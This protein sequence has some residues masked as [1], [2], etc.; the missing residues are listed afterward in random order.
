MENPEHLQKVLCQGI[1]V[2]FVG[3][4]VKVV[5]MPDGNG[6]VVHNF[7]EEVVYFVQVRLG[8]GVIF[9]SLFEG[10]PDDLGEVF[11]AQLVVWNEVT[12]YVSL[13]STVI[14]PHW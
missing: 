4:E 2:V 5:A 7:V 1:G 8:K 14:S 12:R 6:F 10:F 3:R 13:I 9:Q 11:N